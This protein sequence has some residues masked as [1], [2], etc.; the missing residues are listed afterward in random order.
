MRIMCNFATLG[1][2]P[3][4]PGLNIMNEDE[5]KFFVKKV[6]EMRNAQN[7]YFYTREKFDLVC[8]KSIEREVD[9][10]IT[11]MTIKLWK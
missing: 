6:S 1:R 9:K 11:Q 7:R 4:L 10:L 8:S 2:E 5:V 3:K